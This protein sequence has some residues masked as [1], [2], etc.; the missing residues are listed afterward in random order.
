[1]NWIGALAGIGSGLLLE[2]VLL[3]ARL[4]SLRNR[5]PVLP[6]LAGGFLAR[7]ALLLGGTLLGLGAGLWSPT[8]FLL[9]CLTTILLGEAFA[10]W[11]LLRP[12][13]PSDSDSSSA[14]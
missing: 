8:V 1:M 10:F 11:R 6:L 5:Q 9:S 2:A 14:T 3:R 13:P 7:L 12:R 4:R